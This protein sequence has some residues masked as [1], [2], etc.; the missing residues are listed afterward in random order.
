[1]DITSASPLDL[2]TFLRRD[3]GSGVSSELW[4]LRHN[5]IVA[6]ELR[7]GVR[8]FREL[9]HNMRVR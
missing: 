2:R 3:L 6:M 7:S 5:M 9:P 8:R 4:E 1:V